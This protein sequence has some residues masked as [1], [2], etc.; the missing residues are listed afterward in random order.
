MKALPA[1][2][3]AMFLGLTPGHRVAM[4]IV[5]VGLPILAIILALCDMYPMAII[6]MIV[7][8]PL[9]SAII[10]LS[11]LIRQ[12]AEYSEPPTKE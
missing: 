2:V 12:Q 7:V 3:R 8:F 10:S 4:M 11:N 9:A 1:R 6:V 5:I